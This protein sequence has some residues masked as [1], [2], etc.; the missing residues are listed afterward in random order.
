MGSRFSG[1]LGTIALVTA[2][3]FPAGALAENTTGA[4]ANPIGQVLGPGAAADQGIG[5]GA[6]TVGQLQLV[7]DVILK[8]AGLTPPGNVYSG[9]QPPPIC[10]AGCGGGI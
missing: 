2:L 1:A 4:P 8:A 7:D 3:A 6:S 10:G 5:D 9:P